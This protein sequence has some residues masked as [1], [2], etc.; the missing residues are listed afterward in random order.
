M[1]RTG[2]LARFRADG[3]L[4]YLGRIDTQVKLRGFR[5]ELGEIESVLGKHPSVQSAVV[6]VRE[7]TPGDKRRSLMWCPP[8]NRLERFLRPC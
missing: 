8:E 2:D 3:N 6:I 1:Y 4:Q 7:D 5:I